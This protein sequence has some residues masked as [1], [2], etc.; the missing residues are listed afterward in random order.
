MKNGTIGYKTD[1]SL[2][3]IFHD[4]PILLHGEC[5]ISYGDIME[6]II[7]KM[8]HSI[9]K[10]ISP[11][12]LEVQLALEPRQQRGHRNTRQGDVWLGMELPL[13]LYLHG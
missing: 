7:G 2:K 6:D 11:I 12:T 4:I 9:P 8:Y 10:H 5:I 1:Q 3:I 13:L